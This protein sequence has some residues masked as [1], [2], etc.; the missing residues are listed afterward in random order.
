MT[1]PPVHAVLPA[2]VDD[3]ARPSGGNRYDLAVLAAFAAA[4]RPVHRQD[5][6]GDWPRPDRAALAALDG[7]F[8]AVPDGAAVLVDGL[9]GCAAPD[10]VERA[11]RRVRPVLLVH[12]PLADETGLPPAEAAALDAGERRALAAAAAV[13]ATSTATARRLG[14]RL[15][16]R[17]GGRSG[18]RLGGPPGGRLVVAPPGTDPAPA[19]VPSPGGGRLVC[20]AAVTPRK[21][22]DV[23]V[24]ALPGPAG[25]WSLVCAGPTGDPTGEGRGA[26][27]AAAVA[28]RVAAAG[29]ADRV[30]WAGPLAGAD[31]DALWAAADLLVLPSR[32][33]PF[34]MVV[35]EA[36]AR[37]VPVLASDV[38]GVPEALGRAPGGDR[39]GVL[40]PPGD[41]VALRAALHRWLTDPVHR[42]RLRAA[43]AARRPG[44][45]GWDVT[46]ARLADVLADVGEGRR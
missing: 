2:G 34:G 4:G 44:L 40:V 22:H 29:V 13:V 41:P 11:A 24:A 12:L 19:T 1:H 30:R 16:G 5:V 14:G 42:A 23:L 38:D 31:L 17:S 10:A 35:T 3:P 15:G 39:P 28:A 45:P 9:V 43:A 20:V 46:A 6:P 37:A 8:A 33:E 27:H 18:G 21:G 26:G 25:D 36:V 7:A 32:A